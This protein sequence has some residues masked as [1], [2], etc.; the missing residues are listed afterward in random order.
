MEKTGRRSSRVSTA[1]KAEGARPVSESRRRPGRVAS[2]LRLAVDHLCLCTTVSA[3]LLLTSVPAL[4]QE[5]VEE[6][7]RRWSNETEL[8]LVITRGNSETG[9][10]GFRNRFRYNWPTRELS[11]EIGAVRATSR[12]DRFAVGSL[13][14]F[15]IEEPPTDVDSER[16][17]SKLRYL[18]N[19]SDQFFWYGS[20][21]TARDPPASIEHTFVYSGG[22][23]NN[24]V[25][26]ETLEFRTTYGVTYTDE[27]LELEGPND[28][29]GLRLLYDLESQVTGSTKL[30][31]ELTFDLNLEDTSD[32]RIDSYNAVTVSITKVLAIKAGLRLLFRNVPALEE[33]EVFDPVGNI[34]GVGLVPKEKW[35]TNFS[36]SLVINF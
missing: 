19:F 15:V 23:G 35:D 1:D 16:I 11:F 5:E 3:I 9:T 31:S 12:D 26:R 24:W 32:T 27:E 6:E 13:D 20:W 34:L 36:T 2:D 17:Y 22:L 18:Q 14:D 10:I 21:D 30:D 33:I 29:A 4:A 25:D 7:Q 8:S 28:F